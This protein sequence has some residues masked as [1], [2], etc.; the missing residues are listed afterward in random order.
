VR[1]LVL[2]WEKEL[3]DRSAAVLLAS[4]NHVDSVLER[5]NHRIR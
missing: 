2:A 1:M 4:V 5:W 3:T